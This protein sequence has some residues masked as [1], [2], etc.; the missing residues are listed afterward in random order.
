MEQI[1]GNKANCLFWLGRY[2]QRVYTILHFFEKFRDQIIEEPDDY[3]EFCDKLGVYEN[4]Y[5]SVSDF[6]SRILYDKDDESS[7]IAALKCAFNNAIVVRDLTKSDIFSY[8]QLAV[9]KIEEC[10]VK[11]V[12]IND[13]QGVADSAMAFWGAVDERIFN[14]ETRNMI[15]A[16]WFLEDLDLHVRFDYPFSRLKS[17]LNRLEFRVINNPHL[18]DT[19]KFL[20]LKEALAEPGID[21]D[22]VLYLISVLFKL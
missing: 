16:G 12:D 2:M 20:E 11:N 5:S 7:L 3:K 13:L 8:V 21:K 6:M 14:K 19:G 15:K 17:M 18:F 9:D 22:N 10:A 4:K 1:S